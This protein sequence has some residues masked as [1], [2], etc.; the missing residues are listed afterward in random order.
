MDEIELMKRVKLTAKPSAAHGLM[1]P[2][3]PETGPHKKDS[4]HIGICFVRVQIGF[5]IK[6]SDGRRP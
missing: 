4:H 1:D 3:G 5:G 2:L 6:P